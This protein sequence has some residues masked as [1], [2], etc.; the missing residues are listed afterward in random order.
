[1]SPVEWPLMSLYSFQDSMLALWGA[2]PSALNTWATISRS[3]IETTSWG[4]KRDLKI[5]PY[6]FVCSICAT[7]THICTEQNLEKTSSDMPVQ[8]QNIKISMCVVEM[9]SFVEKFR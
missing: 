8:T 5:F 7:K 4:P 9:S 3:A 6:F 1:M 2:V